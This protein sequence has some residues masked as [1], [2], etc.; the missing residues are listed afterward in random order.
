MTKS[1]HCSSAIL[2]QKHQS[3]ATLYKSF[4]LPLMKFLV[5]RVGGDQKAAEEVFSQT[6]VAAWQGW[7]TFESRS[8]Y[9]TWVCK[10]GL[11][12]IAD[13]YRSQVNQRSTFIAPTLE[14]LADIKENRLNP[15]EKIVLQELKN[16]VKNC[17]ML[18]PAEKRQLLYLRY[19][20][21]LTL[22]EIAKLLGITERAAEGKLY[23]ARLAFRE[24][25]SAT[26]PS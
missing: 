14:N 13:Y 18:L 25:Y 6:I 22:G 9:F 5:K 3:F 20:E 10:I 8:S 26:Y 15:E 24:I 7:N 2:S 23:R 21:E 12:K 11:N 1:P 19:W 4:A 16:S 17:L